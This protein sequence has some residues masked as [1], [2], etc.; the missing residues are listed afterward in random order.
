MPMTLEIEAALLAFEA[1]ATG[2]ESR[3]DRAVDRGIPDLEAQAE[4]VVVRQ[5]GRLMSKHRERRTVARIELCQPMFS[6]GILA[7]YGA[8]RAKHNTPSGTVADR[9]GPGN[10]R[11]V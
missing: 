9:I 11:G 10:G 4:E 5:A 2:L 7:P 8:R 1:A 6:C 3:A